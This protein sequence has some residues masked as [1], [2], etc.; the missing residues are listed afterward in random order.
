MIDVKEIRQP[1]VVQK[2]DS[3]P[4]QEPA[5]PTMPMTPRRKFPER[6]IPDTEANDTK[7]RENRDTRA[8]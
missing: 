1:F 6:Q 5:K 3:P 4:L 8:Y 7:A 2:Q